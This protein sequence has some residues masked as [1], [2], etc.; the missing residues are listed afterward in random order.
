VKVLEL[1][2]GGVVGPGP[3]GVPG[4]EEPERFLLPAL[5]VVGEAAARLMQSGE[6]DA[7]I[8]TFLNALEAVPRP[9]R[10]EPGGGRIAGCEDDR[11]K[12]DA[13]QRLTG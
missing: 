13:G 12:R 11:R 3:V 2:L 7:Q 1:Q 6:G 5:E 9:A 8:E 4:D 10:A